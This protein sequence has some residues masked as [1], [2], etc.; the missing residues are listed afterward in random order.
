MPPASGRSDNFLLSG[1]GKG[2]ANMD[3]K[4]RVSGM[5][6]KKN[7][8]VWRTMTGIRKSDWGLMQKEVFPLAVAGIL[9]TV[10]IQ[11]DETQSGDTELEI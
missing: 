5:P 1:C 3:R 9:K 11:S 2:Q 4:V 10:Q 7:F 8:N 6:M